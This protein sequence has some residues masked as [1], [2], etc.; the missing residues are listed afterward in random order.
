MK[1][2][3]FFRPIAGAGRNSG[4][5]CFWKGATLSRVG[6]GGQAVVPDA[7]PSL[8][9][10]SFNLMGVGRFAWCLEILDCRGQNQSGAGW[11]NQSDKTIEVGE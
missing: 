1:K 5:S 8:V 9:Q 6:L 7:K 10:T 3:I 11:N 4:G 2:A